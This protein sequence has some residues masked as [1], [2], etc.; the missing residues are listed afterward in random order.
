MDP[1]T[2]D[3]FCLAC[4]WTGDRAPAGCPACGAPALAT[5]RC[6]ALVSI[7]P[8]SWACDSCRAD[9]RTLLFRGTWRVGSIIWFIRVR[10][11]SGYWC[12]P[13]ARKKTAMSLTYTGLVGWWGFLGAFYW[14]P[15]ATYA[16]WRAVWRPPRKP[17]KWGAVPVD[18][19]VAA[20]AA[21]RT[22]R[23][24]DMWS[25]FDDEGAAGSA[26]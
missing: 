25:A 22:A 16:N 8:G 20:V 12:E 1:P 14:A 15:R 2:A 17:L 5:V 4:G 21:A 23:R 3:L 6:G 24:D 19:A 10:Q 13:C 9:G 11:V 7:P 18:A 26:S